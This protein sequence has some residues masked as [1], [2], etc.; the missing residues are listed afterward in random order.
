MLEISNLKIM[1]KNIIVTGNLG[2]GKTSLVKRVGKLFNWYVINESVTDN[3]Y[4]IDF[5]KDMHSWAFQLQ[6]YFIGDYAKKHIEVTKISQTVIMDRSIYETIHVF[7]PALHHLGF[8]NER[9]YQNCIQIF[10]SIEK[11]ID[12][13]DLLIYLKAP[14]KIIN[15]RIQKRGL[16]FDYKGINEEYLY[17]I[18]SFYK[19][20][21][22]NFDLCPVL[23]IDT[24][25]CNYVNDKQSLL[26]VAKHILQKL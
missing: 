26:L 2:V 25:N 14:L 4:L 21:I 7:T 8:I 5:Y 17:L 13:P 24:G 16:S 3:P 20:W 10:D 6:I 19:K 12:P 18:D 9:D 22:Q 11:F 15:Q 1:N 23:S